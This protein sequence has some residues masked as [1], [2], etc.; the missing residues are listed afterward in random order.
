MKAL[1]V[2]VSRL[3]PQRFQQSRLARGKQRPH[4]THAEVSRP[5]DG[6]LTA[7]H[8]P[9]VLHVLPPKEEEALRKRGKGKASKER[10]GRHGERPST[11]A[12]SISQQ[13]MAVVEQEGLLYL[14]AKWKLRWF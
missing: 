7:P 9:L 4:E 2:C 12:D 13:G 3:N 1:R 6:A 11:A 10:E 14:R 8:L 5:L